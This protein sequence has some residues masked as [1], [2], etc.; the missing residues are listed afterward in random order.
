VKQKP[1]PQHQRRGNG[2]T[3]QP[4]QS[5]HAEPIDIDSQAPCLDSLIQGNNGLK[6]W[7]L[8]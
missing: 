8:Q 3:R 4:D 7:R 2:A 5:H 1:P 6:T